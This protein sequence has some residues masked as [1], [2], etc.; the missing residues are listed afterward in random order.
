[1]M[2]ADHSAGLN[3]IADMLGTPA[4]NR[5]TTQVE[6]VALR[7]EALG[8]LHELQLKYLAEWRAVKDSDEERSSD[9]LSKL[10]LIVN[11]IAGGLRH[12]G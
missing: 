12:T 4:E 7:G 10:L 11:A 3:L 6:N 9:L 5:R 2:M 8:K 1:M